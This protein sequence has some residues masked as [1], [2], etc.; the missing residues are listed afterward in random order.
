MAQSCQSPE[1]ASHSTFVCSTHS[2]RSDFGPKD[3]RSAAH[4]QVNA[5]AVGSVAYQ[6]RKAFHAEEE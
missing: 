5:N 4:W 6:Y 3:M 2:A 1:Q